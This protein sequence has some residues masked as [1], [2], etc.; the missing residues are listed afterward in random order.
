M[1]MPFLTLGFHRT[2]DRN[3]RKYTLFLQNSPKQQEEARV[4][5]LPLKTDK[6]LTRAKA[7]SSLARLAGLARALE[8]ADGLIVLGPFGRN[9]CTPTKE[10]SSSCRGRV[11][12][13]LTVAF[14]GGQV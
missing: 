7:F 14:Q 6:I 11:L 9:C 5:S 4:L 2:Q 1:K 8:A 3:E 12:A 13:L 10:A